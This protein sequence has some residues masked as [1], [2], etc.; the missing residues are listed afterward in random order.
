MADENNLK[1]LKKMSPKERIERLKEIAERDKKEIEE[2]QALIK[3]SEEELTVEEKL[4]RVTIPENKDVDVDRLFHQEEDLEHTVEKEKPRV[5]EE[6]IRQQQEYL[7]ALP[8]QKIEQRAE[9]IQN[10]VQE[11]GYISN[12]QRAELAGMYQEIRQR[13]DGIKQGTYQS[14]SRNIEEQLSTT[15]RIL[16]SMYKR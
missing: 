7:K 11:T 1:D 13:E 5:S 3:E 9:Y 8:T 4:K 16:G 6:E 15:K 12:E 2:A 14:S 10:K